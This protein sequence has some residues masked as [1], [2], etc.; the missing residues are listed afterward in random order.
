MSHPSLVEPFPVTDAPGSPEATRPQTPGLGIASPAQDAGEAKF[1]LLADAMP[2]IV[3]ITRPD[4]YHEYYNKHWWD[5]TG[6]T[7]E[8]ARGE[9]WNLLLHPDDLQRSIH[10]WEEALRTGEPYEIEYRFRRASDGAYRWFL[11]RALPQCDEAGRI[12]RWF[13]T[14]TDIH[15]QKQA[16][17]NLRQNNSRHQ[18]AL[19][20]GR[21]ATWEMDLETGV[22]SESDTMGPLFGQPPGAQRQ[23]IDEW[24]RMILPE[25]RDRVMSRFHEAVAVR[26][27]F[28]VEYRAVGADGVTRWIEGHGKVLQNAEGQPVKIAGVAADIT[29]RKQVEEELARSARRT[30]AILESITDAFFSLD[31]E[32][33][34][35]YVNEQAERL[36]QRSK[37]QLLDR[38][39]WEEFPK[40]TGSRFEREYHRAMETNEPVSFEE[41]YSPLNSWFEVHAYPSE[42]GLSVY[43]HDITKK[44]EAEAEREE[45][46]ISERAARTEAERVSRMKDE[47]LA[48]LS[49]ELRTPLNAILG[50]SQVLR[51]I[52]GGDEDLEEGLAV[53]ERNARVQTQLIEDLLD[54]SRIISGKLRLDVQS[55]DLIP[56]IEAAIE[57][58]KPAADAREIRLHKVLDPLAGPI[59]GDPARLQQIIWN[60]LS[61]A[62]KFTPRQGRVQITLERVNSHVE[63]TVSDTGLGIKPEF[64]PHL[65]ERFR[66]ADASTTRQH[67]GLGLGLAIVKHLAEMHGGSIRAQSPGENQGATFTFHL[68]LSIVHRQEALKDEPRQHPRAFLGAPAFDHLVNL[69]KVRIL[70]VDDEPDGRGLVKR[71]LEECQASAVAAG[72]AEEGLRLLRASPPDVL[73]S[74]IGMPGEDGYQFLRKVRELGPEE[75]GRTPAIA[76]TAFARSEDRRRAMLAGFDMHVAKPVEPSELIAIVARLAGRV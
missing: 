21:L 18:I 46:L 74:D 42:E 61:N 64:L 60:L 14:C 23:R 38:S 59:M 68:P 50:W 35:T 51:T 17:E 4:G 76:L 72:S 20:A 29:A 19:E 62:L 30:R 28:H 39:L 41:L 44:K 75:G 43:F 9:G 8:Q 71:I 54:M 2:Q 11:G 12:V 45:L 27:S 66:Q 55:V 47:F 52:P 15:S 33:R 1:R 70:I 36:L 3:W 65:F 24:R 25:D 37:D 5:Y 31:R 6:L 7:Y 67:G 10:R 34:F 53:I 26:G 40:A 69:E 22:F 56:V 32:W 73:I 49:H 58:V 63:I 16:E 13:G 57:T 48:N